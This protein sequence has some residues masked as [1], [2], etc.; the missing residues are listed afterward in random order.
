MYFCRL[1]FLNFHQATH[2]SLIQNESY[3]QTP[4][5]TKNNGEHKKQYNKQ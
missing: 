4:G 3:R 5:K 2:I 1:L